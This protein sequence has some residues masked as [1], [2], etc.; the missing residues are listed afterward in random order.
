MDVQAKM[1]AASWNMS[2]AGD[3]HNEEESNNVDF[4]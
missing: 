3:N 2:F 4:S 1:D